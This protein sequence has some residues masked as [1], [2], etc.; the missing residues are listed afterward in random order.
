MD[1]DSNKFFKYYFAPNRGKLFPQ[2]IELANLAFKHEILNEGDKICHVVT[3]SDDQ[4]DLMA[5]FY[6]IARNLFPPK[7]AYFGKGVRAKM[8]MQ[9]KLISEGYI[10]NSGPGKP[11]EYVPRYI[12]IRSLINEQRYKDAVDK[13]YASLGD[14]YYGELH[15]ELI[16]LK[17]IGNMHLSG[18]DLL[19]FRSESDRCE[20]V[21]ANIAEYCQCV[22]RVIDDYK[23]EGLQLPLDILKK[24]TFTVSEVDRPITIVFLRDGR[25]SGKEISLLDWEYSAY[26]RSGRLFD[27]YIDQVKSCNVL[28]PLHQEPR[29]SHLWTTNSPDYFNK[30]IIDRGYHL[31]NLDVY[32]PMNWRR[33]KRE[34]TF[35]S[36]SFLTDIVK[37]TIGASAL[38]YTGR[39][40]KIEERQFYEV[41]LL[42]SNRNGQVL[43]NE[44]LDLV[45]EILRGA[46]NLLRERHGLPKIG[47]GWISEMTLFKLIESVFPDVEHHVNLPWLAPQHL[48]IY[49]P[50]KKLAFEY[51]GKQHYEPI[52]FFGGIA[53]FEKR[54]C[55]DALKMKKC[56][57]NN[58]NLIYWR[59]D[60]P[61][62]KAILDK[63]ISTATS[64]Q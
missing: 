23:K 49:V 56:Q 47:E 29:Y 35:T 15:D 1:D 45:D 30:E 60:E 24:T 21:R 48:D 55:L 39:S 17:C 10:I 26:S 3:F 58:I 9:G 31:V 53:A 61:I 4:L 34:T 41:N 37:E 16:Y 6:N 32:K 27:K 28:E 2:A 43:G 50:S 54:K 62:S 18:R 51:N 22:D 40:H 7:G 20:L 19:F 5:S 38:E 36:L 14:R 57:A 63:K 64:E 33:G 42:R 59:Y 25:I 52:E 13:Y 8:A 11:A 12:E 46:E 44:F